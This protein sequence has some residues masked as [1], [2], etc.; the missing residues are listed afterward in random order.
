MRGVVV[1]EQIQ[2]I[3]LYVQEESADVWKENILEDL[4]EGL[5][6]YKTAEEFWA[7]IKR[8]FGEEDEEIVQTAKLK[9]LEQKER[10]ME[11]FV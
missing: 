7:K 5:L 11:E 4:K 9:R 3:L 6:E 8:E 2:W 10:I 1:V